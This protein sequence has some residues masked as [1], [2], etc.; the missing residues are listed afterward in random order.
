MDGRWEDG[1]EVGKFT[2][3]KPTRKSVVDYCLI[4]EQDRKLVNKFIVDDLTIH[5]KLEINTAGVED[6]DQEH[7]SNP[8][9]AYEIGSAN[10][11]EI[12]ELMVLDMWLKKITNKSK[13]VPKFRGT[14]NRAR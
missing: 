2:C 8:K 6:L 13:R 14:G 9:E 3:I 7:E 1:S 12:D 11:N 4:R 10:K 5:L